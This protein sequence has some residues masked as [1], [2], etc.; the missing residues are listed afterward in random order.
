MP[1][2]ATG[3]YAPNF[4]RYLN[5]VKGDS[6]PAI[7]QTYTASIAAFY[8]SLPEDKA[9]YAYSAGKWT[10]KDVLQHVI[11]AE[12]VFS[13]RLLRI[14]RNDKTPLPGFDENAFA[15]NVNTADRTLQSLKDEFNAVRAASEYLLH[16]LN[17]TQLQY[18]GT[19][20]GYPTTANV[21]AFVIYGHLLH[22][23]QIIHE[24]YL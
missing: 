24:R 10:I 1:R 11:D 4:E 2:P 22:H 3:E 16:S 20:S 9:D 14:A 6:I 19:S 8:N 13:Y 12:R 5:L 7:S 23:Q 17:E 15:S 21:F 18:K